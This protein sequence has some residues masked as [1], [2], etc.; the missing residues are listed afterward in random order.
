MHKGRFEL[1]SL[2]YYH[3][4]LP[5]VS[6]TFTY[7]SA[8]RRLLLYDHYLATL[9]SIYSCLRYLCTEMVD[10]GGFEPPVLWFKVRCIAIM[11]RVIEKLVDINRLERIRS[12][13]QPDALPLELYVLK[14]WWTWQG[15]NLHLRGANAMLNQYQ[16]QAHE[17]LV[18]TDG[19]WTHAV[20][21]ANQVLKP[22][23][24]SGPK[25]C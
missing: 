2:V 9:R 11:L 6:G 7:K 19:N 10:P 3:K 5:K 17:K 25:N 16:L 24:E 4:A 18:D 14:N 8:F 21:I 12:G 1:P 23:W 15:S 13:L 20:L 22:S